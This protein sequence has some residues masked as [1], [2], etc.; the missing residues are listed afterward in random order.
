LVERGF[1]R[2]RRLVEPD[3]GVWERA[4][5]R[6]MQACT[7]LI[8]AE[9]QRAVDLSLDIASAPELQTAFAASVRTCARGVALPAMYWTGRIARLSELVEAWGHDAYLSGDRHLE[10]SC[11]VIGA[12][13]HLRSDDL[14]R[15]RADIQSAREV[16]LDYLHNV[17]SDPWWHANVAMYAGEPQAA[18]DIC[19]EMLTAF[20][21][22]SAH[23]A[24][25]RNMWDLTEGTCAAALA[26]RGI[27]RDLA[28]ARL[29]R[30]ARA[31]RR[32]GAR[33]AT[34]IAEQLAATLALQRG[35][36]RRSVEC[37]KRAAS[38][39]LVSGMRL[40]AAS[41]ELSIARLAPR[42][43][44][45]ERSAL[46]VFAEEGIARPDRWAYM[47]APGLGIEWS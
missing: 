1:A 2:A 16:P 23:S 39:Y 38:A 18:L 13:G 27:D 30:S 40:H 35:E 29:E 20:R 19:A 17:F 24:P 37:L 41:L 21:A 33:G 8:Q 3:G 7:M 10:V 9:P 6:V 22:R 32:S 36:R 15:A 47:R 43:L 14:A 4:C 46:A 12:H 34:A 28:L 31:A 26:A 11:K 45:H 25:A 42:Q 44:A 5:V